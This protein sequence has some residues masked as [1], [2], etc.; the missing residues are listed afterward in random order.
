MNKGYHVANFTLPLYKKETKVVNNGKRIGFADGTLI[1]Y[2]CK[3]TGK[4]TILKQRIVD[5]IKQQINS[6]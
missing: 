1:V 2:G 4:S 3:R 5:Y 6:V